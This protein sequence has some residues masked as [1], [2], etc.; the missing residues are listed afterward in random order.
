MLGNIT[1][2]GEIYIVCGYT[3][4]RRSIDVLC[5]IV[6]DR[7]R[8]DPR[9][10]AL[11]LFCGKRCDRIKCLLW[12]NEFRF[13]PA[14]GEVVGIY[15][16]TAKCPGCSTLSAMARNI[17]FVEAIPKGKELDCSNP[18]AQ[19]VQYCNKLFEY[20]RQSRESG[21]TFDQRKEYRLQKEKPV[22]DAFWAWVSSQA[23]KKGT[24]FEKAVNYAQNYKE[25]F[26]TYLEDGRCSFSNNLSENPIRPFTVGRKNWLFSDTPKGAEASATVYTM[27]EMA[28]AHGLNIYKY[29]KYLLEHLPGTKMNDHYGL[30]KS[31]I[32][33]PCN[34]RQQHFYISNAAARYIIASLYFPLCTN[35]FYG[36]PPI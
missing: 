18:A 33:T 6:Q 17:Q 23:P 27:V 34:N 31:R 11:Y 13:T 14:K 10:R 3:G 24:R 2:A 21:H 22:L 4:R 30:F 20:E 16:E 1:A 25:Q 36:L 5:A 29:L 28:G 32:T 35:P 12:E 26:L 9:R 7:L 19:G 15:R 8:M